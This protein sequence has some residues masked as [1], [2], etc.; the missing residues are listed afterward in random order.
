MACGAV[1]NSS[2]CFLGVF[3]ARDTSACSTCIASTCR[4]KTKSTRNIEEQRN[5]LKSKNAVNSVRNTLF[6][7]CFF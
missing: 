7:V 3:E 2:S 1:M 5:S 4:S 6:F